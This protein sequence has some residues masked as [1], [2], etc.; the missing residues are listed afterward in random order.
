M[1]SKAKRE[2][3]HLRG[4]IFLYGVFFIVVMAVFLSSC[5]KEEKMPVKKVVRP[6]KMMTVESVG[7]SFKRA[8]P[9]KVQASQQVDLAFKVSGPLIKLPVVEGQK[10]RKNDLLARIDPRDFEV[11][12]KDAKGQIGRARANLKAMRQARPEDIKK[13]TA[14]VD[15][16]QAALTLGKSGYERVM[17]IKEADPG[18]VSQGMIDKAVEKRDRAEAEVRKAKEELRIGKAGARPEDIQ[19]K[20]AEIRS[21]AANVD[22]AKDR[23]NDTYLKAPFSGV[24]AR[25]YVDNF[26]EVRAKQPIV[27]L[28]DISS[29]EIQINVPESIMA[30]FKDTGKAGSAV[31][32]F[33]AAPGKQYKL[34]L[35][36][37]S[38]EADPQTQAY[39]VT[40]LM[41]Q[42]EDLNV[43]PGMTANV[44]GTR[45]SE[46]GGDNQIVIP[47]VAVFADEAGS[48]HIWVVDKNSKKVMRRKVTTGKLTGTAGILITEGLETGETIAVAGVSRLREGMEVRPLTK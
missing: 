40:L 44:V 22:S 11:S 3:V 13:L 19:A 25:K 5:G 47:A 38:T 14:A 1:K 17:R 43:L 33:A 37:Y 41:P 15:K 20:K 23:L 28:Q 48:T 12:L 24:I 7:H 9:G 26:Q 2:R 45:S 16:A 27:S 4:R 29:L 46:K 42:P 10:V 35:K 21:I 32:E 36:E 30:G 8:F 39:K 6:V 34:T 31:A 18:A